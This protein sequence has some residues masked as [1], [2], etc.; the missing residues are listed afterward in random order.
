MDAIA[1][2]QPLAAPV[3]PQAQ[4]RGAEAGPQR[5]QPAGAEPRLDAQL[6]S[7]AQ[8]RSA[9][10]VQPPAQDD[11]RNA[12]STRRFDSAES[13]ERQRITPSA[14]PGGGTAGANGS[15]AARPAASSGRGQTVDLF[16]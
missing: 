3:Q 15:Q 7:G 14:F 12:G 11:S 9:Q 16:V 1:F 2:S 5:S 13:G 4:P 10:A 8:T 6:R